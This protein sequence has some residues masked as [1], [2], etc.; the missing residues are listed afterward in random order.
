MRYGEVESSVA[1]CMR[2]IISAIF[3]GVIVI[4]FVSGY[5]LVSDI[6]NTNIIFLFIGTALVGSLSYL[7]WY[8]A[9]NLIGV[10]RGMSLNITYIVWT[11]IFS[12]LVLN[13][14][15]NFQ[16]VI[17]SLII[18]LGVVMLSKKEY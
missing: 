9:I 16:F 2:Q 10:P 13:T 11:M 14:D 12:K 17:A 15:L 5:P 4:S 6:F 8:K 7:F 1:I 3:Y 18:F